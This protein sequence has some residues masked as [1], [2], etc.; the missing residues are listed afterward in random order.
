MGARGPAPKRSSE[1]RR[2]NKESTVETVTP[3]STGVVDAPPAKSTWHPTAKQWY[4]S[5]KTSGQSQFY[6]PSDWWYAQYLAEAMSIN[7][8]QKGKF[9]AV[10]LATVTSGMNDLLTTEASRRR[11]RLEIDRSGQDEG[12][13]PGVAAMDDYRKR[14]KA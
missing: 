12:A 13:L 9:S 11:V 14:L 5:L 3:I 6:E 1:R 4:E 10:L 8:R 7:L 2:R